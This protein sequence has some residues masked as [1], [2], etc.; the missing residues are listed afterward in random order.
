MRGSEKDRMQPLR[1]LDE[2]STLRR[3]W[4]RAERIYGPRLAPN[5]SIFDFMSTDE[6]SLSRMIAWLVDPKGSHAQGAVFLQ[7]LTSQAAL[8]WPSEAC[9]SATVRVE[10][11]YRMDIHVH[12]STGLGDNRAFA[13]ENKLRGAV[14]Q[15]KQLV[16]YYKH[17]AASTSQYAILYIS[18]GGK[19]P[20]NSSLPE[21]DRLTREQDGTLVIWD[22]NMLL[23]W[24]EGCR[25]ACK[26]ESVRLFL[27]QFGLFVLRELL[28][29]R[30]KSE[31]IEMQE[32]I[33]SDRERIKSFFATLA[34]ESGVKAALIERLKGQL[35][36]EGH[37]TNLPLS[38]WAMDGSR[39]SGFRLT[40]P[41]EA[42]SA[43][44]EFSKKRLRLV[45][46]RH[47]DTWR[48]ASECGTRS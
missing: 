18:P 1:L 15:D 46:C 47:Q 42:Y 24:I 41:G 39:F 23:R 9:L 30:D 31:A 2:L 21:E 32:H 34:V 16:R 26:A 25:G 45:S 48:G 29:I 14:D 11:P 3:S 5:F 35:L 8:N 36:H 20:E 37:R 13:I 12:S 43:S 40:R 27:E 17:L 22:E 44:F 7:L 28:G 10:R 38:E 4:S 6:T 33:A 19:A